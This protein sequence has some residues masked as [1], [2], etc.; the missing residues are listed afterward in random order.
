MIT[1]LFTLCLIAFVFKL[2]LLALKATWGITKV[3]FTIVL[4]PAF[5]IIMAVSGL[6]VVAFPI[7][8]IAGIAL[9]IRKVAVGV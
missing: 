8:I 7:L 6:M 3:I 5:L 2:V 9:V 4:F 1:L